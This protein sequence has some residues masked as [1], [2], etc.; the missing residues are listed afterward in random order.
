VL[1]T[2][3]VPISAHL[4]YNQLA[5][6][7]LDCLGSTKKDIA[8]WWPPFDVIRNAHCSIYILRPRPHPTLL[9][10]SWVDVPNDVMLRRWQCHRHRRSCNRCSVGRVTRFVFGKRLSEVDDVWHCARRCQMEWDRVYMMYVINYQAS[11]CGICR[12]NG[13][14]WAGKSSKTIIKFSI[15]DQ[16]FKKKNSFL[17][18]ILFTIFYIELT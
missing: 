12:L 3:L 17:Y 13:V 6:R 4:V 11:F 8:A 10:T 15:L 14:L 2:H 1:A 16:F 7:R 5:R 9:T 18:R